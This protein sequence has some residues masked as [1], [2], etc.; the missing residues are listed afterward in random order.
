MAFLEFDNVSLSFPVYNSKAMSFRNRL[1]NISTGGRLE[2][3]TAD[4]VHVSALKN[5]SFKL[6]SGDTVGLVGHNGA[7]KSTTLRTMA[8]IYAPTA[9]TVTREGNV[10]TVFELGAGMEPELSGYD[11]IRRMGV[12]LGMDQSKIKAQVKDIEEF[13][14]LGDFLQLPV[15][16]YSTGMQMRLMFAMAT[17]IRPNVLLI[18]EMF[19]AGDAAFQERAAERM[20]ALLSSVD[21][22][23]FASHSMEL[24]KQHCKKC[25]RLEHGELK[26]FG[27]IDQMED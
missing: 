27:D 11:N 5:V 2:Q 20:Q 17:T 22:L 16:T 21:I 18:D 25:I 6:E 12:L 4:I 14:E 13:T 23:V 24:I 1:V 8:G 15:R 7:G 19:G 10:A 26:Y 3:E 9:G